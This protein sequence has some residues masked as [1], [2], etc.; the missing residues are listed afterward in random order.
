ME[1]LNYDLIFAGEKKSLQR[2][3]LLATPVRKKGHKGKLGRPFRGLLSPTQ[4]R[5][6]CT[7]LVHKKRYII[8]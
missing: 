8:T 2:T 3:T 7:D 6:R 4:T 5:V 1:Y